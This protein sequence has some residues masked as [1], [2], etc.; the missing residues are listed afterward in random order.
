[1]IVSKTFAP[2]LFQDK[3]AL[4]TG[5]GTGIGR[6]TA[7]MLVHLGAKVAICGRRPEKLDAAVAELAAIHGPEQV[8]ALPC[9]IR[10][11]EQV[12][13]LVGGT[14]DKLGRIDF[15]VNNA[16]GQFPSPAE[17]ISSRGFEAV[18]RNNL[19]GTWNVTR[20]VATRAMMKQK[21]KGGRIINIIAQ[22]FRGFPGMVHTGAARAG[23][24]N[25]SMTLSV[26]WA[27]HDILVNALA[28]GVIKSSGTDRYPPELL[29]MQRTKTPLKRLGTEEEV[30]ENILFLLSPASSFTTGATLYMDGGARLWG[31]NWSIPERR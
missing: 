5:G 13:A 12:A 10:E 20:E 29:E 26:E 19:L 15:L 30:A 23:V 1:M 25:M 11:P 6:V 21:P 2:G 14:L 27:E 8:F 18:V 4:V 7:H 28:P 3:V 16:G 9:D 24:E 31:E 22:I 17:Q